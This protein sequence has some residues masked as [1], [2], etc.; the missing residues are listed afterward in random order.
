MTTGNGTARFA[1]DLGVGLQPHPM[2]AITLDS[3][4]ADVTFRGDGNGASETIADVAPI[5]VEG[6]FTPVRW[7]DFVGTFDLPDVGGGVDNY[8]LRSAV[9][10]R[11]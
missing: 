7:L 1:F 8:A 5:V 4:I 10:V 2:F 6:T 9:R 11:F 3:R